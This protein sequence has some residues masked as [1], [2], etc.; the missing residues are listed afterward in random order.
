MRR[1]KGYRS[2]PDL[3]EELKAKRLIEL[4]YDDSQGNCKV[5]GK[6]GR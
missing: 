5:R 3:L 6:K 2:F 1:V 4:D